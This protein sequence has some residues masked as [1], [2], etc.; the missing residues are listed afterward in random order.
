[1][2]DNSGAEKCYGRAYAGYAGII[3]TKRLVAKIEVRAFLIDQN[4]K[5]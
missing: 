2:T 5:F 1:M 4:R 3:S